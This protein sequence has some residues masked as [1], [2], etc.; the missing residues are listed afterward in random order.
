MAAIIT[1]IVS[2]LSVDVLVPIVLKLFGGAIA[3]E[4]VSGAVK[5]ARGR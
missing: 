1:M 3:R 2:Y 5:K 4:T